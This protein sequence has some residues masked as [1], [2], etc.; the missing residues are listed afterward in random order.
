MHSNILIRIFSSVLLAPL[1]LAIIW[2]GKSVYDVYGVPV[3][4]IFLGLL[5]AGLAWEW[6]MMF[7]KKQTTA[8]LWMTISAMLTAFISEDNPAFVLW[9]ILMGTTLSFWKSKGRLAFSLGTAYICLP[10]LALSSLYYTNGDDARTLVLWLVFVVWATDI[11][12]YIVGKT[13]GGPKLC[14]AIS[15]KKTWA[16]LLGAIGFA[17][18]VA[19]VFALFLKAY[20]YVNLPIHHTTR[21]LVFSAG[22]LAVISQIGDLFESYIKRKLN[23]KDSS[24]LIPGHGG[25]FDRVDGLIF[26]AAI[27]AL[28]IYI[29]NGGVLSS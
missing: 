22:I 11:G 16:G 12:G 1:V 26:A 17:M 5:G 19:Y 29:M 13:I 2:Y 15:P 14:P 20:E 27:T 7:N 18:L 9:V 8:G 10:L 3:F 21:L 28:A 25:L 6:D 23:L 24:D 4:K